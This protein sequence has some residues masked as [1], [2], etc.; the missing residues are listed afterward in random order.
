MK[1][2]L[3]KMGVDS[4]IEVV[5]NGV[6]LTH[7]RGNIHPCPRSTF[8]FEDQDI[9]L[10]YAGRL[11][12]EKN[13]TFLMR[14]FAGLHHA[15]PATKLLLLG[16]GPEHDNLVRLSSD[17]G[18]E[19][20]VCFPGL[21]PYERLPEHLAMCDAFV[22]ASVTEVHPLS[23]IE[24]MAVGL[25]VLGIHSPGVSDTV[26]DEVTGFLATEDLASFT[27][28][29]VRLAAGN[30][31]RKRMGQA[32]QK[33]VEVYDIQRTSDLVVAHYE[34]LIERRAHRGKATGNRIPGI[35]RKGTA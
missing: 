5:P 9:V 23:V 2:V 26:E 17:L 12:P 18:I 28:K 29:M 11:A 34:R 3:V 16:S 22:T 20:A 33:A 24:A 15:F 19:R 13:L 1:S 27:A 14:S 8:G 21:I 4:P 6:D 30:D 32:A 35:G 25:P 10:V 31:Q 7:F